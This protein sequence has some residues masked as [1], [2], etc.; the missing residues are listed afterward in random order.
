MNVTLDGYEELFRDFLTNADNEYRTYKFYNYTE[1]DPSHF[2]PYLK[3]YGL[4]ILSSLGGEMTAK[5]NDAFCLASAGLSACEI[6][7][8]CI[9]YW[10][11][12]SDVYYHASVGIHGDA[13]KELVPFSLIQYMRRSRVSVCYIHLPICLIQIF[14]GGAELI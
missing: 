12:I 14:A 11:Y 5:S 2:V 3:E 10:F 4:P 8:T 7:D 9:E 1:G 13:V 6:S